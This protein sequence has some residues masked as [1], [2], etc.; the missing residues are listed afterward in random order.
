[1]KKIDAVVVNET[2]YIAVWVVILSAL[3]QAVF[4]V[5]GKWH[6]S[7]LLGNILSG[8]FAVLNFLLM[9]ITVQAAVLKEEKEARTAIKVSQMYRNLM[10]LVVTIIGVVLPIFN[11]VAVIVPVFFPRVAIS[12]RPMFDKK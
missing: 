4:L 10:I 11:T 6:Y 1:M 9:G 7:V 12:F 5:I 2:K 3:M 8:T